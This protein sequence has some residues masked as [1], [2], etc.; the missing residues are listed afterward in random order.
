[1]SKLAPHIGEFAE[2][3]QDAHEK[4]LAF[5]FQNKKA[6]PM[7]TIQEFERRLE[8]FRKSVEESNGVEACAAYLG[9]SLAAFFLVGDEKVR[10]PQLDLFSEDEEGGP[11]LRA[12][13]GGGPDE[14]EEGE[15]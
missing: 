9:S 10:D 1:M 15:D 4:D 3:V 14:E 12:V 6:K 8:L 5:S 2:A 13:A 11:G 7:A